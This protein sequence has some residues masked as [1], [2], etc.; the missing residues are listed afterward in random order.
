MD[1]WALLG[2][3]MK[4]LITTVGLAAVMALPVMATAAHAGPSTD[5]LAQCLV[6]ST[7]V[8][9]HDVL[10]RWIFAM[11]TRHPSVASM[12]SISDAQRKDI[13]Q[14]AG[15]LFTRLLTDNCATEVKKAYKDEGEPAIEA[16]FANLGATAMQDIMSD[17]SVQAAGGDI[18][19]YVD[20]AKLSA[21]LSQ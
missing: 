8:E 3:R 17:P 9:D 18:Q 11:V 2:V 16:A 4:K 7:T 5:A 14:K 15:A 12:T 19:P 20:N 6:R 21:L 10:E 13:N 1:R